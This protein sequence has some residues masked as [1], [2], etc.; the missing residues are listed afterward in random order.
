MAKAGADDGTRRAAQGGWTDR[1]MSAVL[2]VLGLVVVVLLYALVARAVMPRVDPLREENPAALVG[3]IIQVEV[4][5]GCGVDGLAGTMTMYLRRHGFDV[6]E[7]GNYTSFDEP[8]SLV[9]DR[10]GDPEAARKVARALGIDEA[11]V[12]Q[13]VRPDLFVDASVVIGEDYATLKPFAGN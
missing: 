12:V 8:H 5:N 13:E 2:V 10:V 11:R 6:V 7:V 3:E 9:I 1:L 4:R